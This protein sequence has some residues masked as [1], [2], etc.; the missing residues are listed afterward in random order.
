MIECE[1]DA[2]EYDPDRWRQSDHWC[3]L[4]FL[5]TETDRKDVKCF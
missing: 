4:S 1:R 5:H 2:L 3:D